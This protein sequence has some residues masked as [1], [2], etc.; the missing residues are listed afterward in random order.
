M[1]IYVYLF[2][3]SNITNRPQFQLRR[4][5]CRVAP[6]FSSRRL[7][8]T[9]GW[10]SPSTTQRSTASD[11]SGVVSTEDAS[12]I[13][14]RGSVRLPVRHGTGSD[15][16]RHGWSGGTGRDQ[17]GRDSQTTRDGTVR[18]H[19]MGRSDDTGW[20]G[21]TTR[22]GTVR[23][24]RAKRQGTHGTGQPNVPVQHNTSGVENARH[25]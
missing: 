15:S 25:L 21:Q 12:T 20:D 5:R 18:R 19:G 8:V 3:I 1:C 9:I 2:D 10:G 22:D 23:R 4:F 16:K 24:H 17:M 6:T 7:H 11:P 14:A 13:R